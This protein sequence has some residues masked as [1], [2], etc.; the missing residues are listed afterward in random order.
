MRKRSSASEEACARQKRARIRAKDAAPVG[1]RWYQMGKCATMG[2]GQGCRG[3]RTVS[4]QI[5]EELHTL[6]DG[7]RERRVYTQFAELVDE[8]VGQRHEELPV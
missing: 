5:D 7:R 2:R 8:G 6:L 3:R 1:I 4:G